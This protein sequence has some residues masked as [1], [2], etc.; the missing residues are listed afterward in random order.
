MKQILAVLLVFGS[1]PAFAQTKN[2]VA[3]AVRDILARQQKNITAAVEEMPADKYNYKP[4][5]EQMS[6]AHLAMHIS[7]ANSRLCSLVSDT[8]A[9]KQDELKESDGKD[10]LVAAVKASFDFCA[11]A[12]EK[13]DD[14]KLSDKV[15]IFG[16][17]GTKASALFSLSGSWADHYGAAA[18]Y[19]RL[20]GLLPPTAKK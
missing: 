11:S 8:P 6:F 1:Y 7:E 10:K 16:H 20:N 19:L 18:I 17:E 5:P 3:S 9:P 15:Q 14:S 12:L 4:T 2:P 13:V